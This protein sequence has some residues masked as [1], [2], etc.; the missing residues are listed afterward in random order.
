MVENSDFKDAFVL[1]KEGNFPAASEAYAR[2]YGEALQDG[3]E[4]IARMCFDQLVDVQL[5]AL[6]RD[7]AMFRNVSELRRGVRVHIDEMLLHVQA[8][9]EL[10]S[11]HF[12][13]SWQ[14][15]PRQKDGH[16]LFSVEKE[17][18]VRVGSS[19]D[20]DGR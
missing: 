4:Y 15:F 8:P 5:L 3:N 1:K 16:P 9:R 17:R 11:E 13:L 12:D 20:P 19:H 10:V 18:L 7:G 2:S 14:K 6:L